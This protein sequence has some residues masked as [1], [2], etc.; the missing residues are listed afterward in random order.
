VFLIFSHS[1]KIA[2]QERNCQKE[3]PGEFVK[4]Q[5]L[6]DKIYSYTNKKPFSPWQFGKIGVFQFHPLRIEV[7]Q[8]C[9]LFSCVRFSCERKL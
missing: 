7:K 6:N 8:D 2:F 9:S 1:L 4:L 5:F 3:K